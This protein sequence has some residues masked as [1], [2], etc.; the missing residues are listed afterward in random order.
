MF[1][2]SILEVEEAMGIRDKKPFEQSEEKLLRLEELLNVTL[3]VFEVTL[4]SGYDDNSKD[5][6]KHLAI[7]QIYS[8]HK[9]TSLLSLC[10]LNH[11]RDTNPFP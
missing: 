5:K 7:S 10:I 11:T 9:S 4:L 1:G 8:G 2:V 3:N 6:N